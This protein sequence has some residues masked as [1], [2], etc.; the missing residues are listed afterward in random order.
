MKHK[1]PEALRLADAL[2]D[3]EH[4][5]ILLEKEAA[6]ELRRLYEVNEELLKTMRQL[7]CLGMGDRYGNS[8]GTK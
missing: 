5:D 2:D 6:N 7:A 8:D 1:Q 4:R 3:T